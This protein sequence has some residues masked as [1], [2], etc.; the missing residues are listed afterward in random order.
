MSPTRRMFLLGTAG[1]CLLPRLTWAQQA[2]ASPHVGWISIETQPD[3]FI[4]GFRA[5]LRQEGYV[6]GT[7][8]ILDLRYSPGNIEGLTAAV[9]D[10][11][12][13]KVR[14]IVSSGLATRAVKGVENVPVLF[15]ISGDPVE[16][17]VANSLN[18][19]GRNFTGIT[20]MSMEIAGKR[21][22]LIKEAVPRLRTLA[23]LSNVDHPGEPSERRATEAAAHPLG[24]TIAYVPFSS[25][26]QLDTAFDAL[27]QARPDAMIVFPEGTTMSRRV[28]I[29]ELEGDH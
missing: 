26:G 14:F 6:E 15:A 28:K 18:K 29:L 25:I 23:V 7:N 4:D 2:K 1:S 16:L 24:V 11:I 9:A 8:V 5:G 22:E 13:R 27:R 21:V 20:F 3:P 10:L 12:Q 19:P 17:G